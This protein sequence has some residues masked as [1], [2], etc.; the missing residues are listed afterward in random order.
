MKHIGALMT[1]LLRIWVVISMTCWCLTAEAQTQSEL[2]KASC[3]G[4]KESEARLRTTYE[5]A[6]ERNRS[7]RTF[8]RKFAKAQQAWRAYRDSHLET[9]YPSNKEKYGTALEAC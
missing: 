3:S 5:Q 1:L 9:V 4:L 8:V 6:V 2:T 7:D